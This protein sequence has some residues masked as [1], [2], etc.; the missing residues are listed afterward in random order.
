MGW[1]AA[2]ASFSSAFPSPSQ[3]S[4]LRPS[5]ARMSRSSLRRCRISTSLALA[6]ESRSFTLASRAAL[7]LIWLSDFDLL[8]RTSHS[9]AVRLRERLVR[10]ASPAPGPAAGSFLLWLTRGRSRS[11][12]LAELGSLLPA[13]VLRLVEEAV[14]AL[15]LGLFS[16][17]VM[18]GAEAEGAVGGQVLFF[19]LTP[20][21][22]VTPAAMPASRSSLLLVFDN[23]AAAPG[24]ASLPPADAE[25][26]F[27]GLAFSTVCVLL[28][29]DP[30]GTEPTLLLA[31][32]ILG[33]LFAM[34]LQANRAAPPRSLVCW[35]WPWA[36][37]EVARWRGPIP[38]SPASG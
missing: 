31:F 6:S 38:L 26:P 10:A 1:C 4:S 5:W 37:G 9:A 22:T 14:P 20:F 2:A 33:C 24:F 15:I 28:T 21:A 13:D 25:D 36:G 19:P 34:H 12:S 11:L 32:F 30:L 7:S 27:S 16:T 29:P 23:A 3:G 35:L 8:M 17:E 18:A